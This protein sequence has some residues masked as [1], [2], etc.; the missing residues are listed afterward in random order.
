[1]IITEDS[2][3]ALTQVRLTKG[4]LYSDFASVKPYMEPDEHIAIFND[5][6]APDSTRLNIEI[7]NTL[8]M[9]E[10]NEPCFRLLVKLRNTS[11]KNL[12]NIA[13]AYFFDWD[14]GLGGNDNS[15]FPFDY[16]LPITLR[17]NPHCLAA[18]ISRQGN[19]EKIATAVTSNYPNSE[20]IFASF[21]NSVTQGENLFS[22]PEQIHYLN[23]GKS[24]VYDNIDDIAVIMGMKFPGE[25]SQGD[26]VSF[27]LSICLQDSLLFLR[28]S[29]W[30]FL[31]PE[32]SNITNEKNNN[33]LLIYPN[34]AT[35]KIIISGN[36][37]ISLELV[38][39]LGNT[40]FKTENNTE[41]PFVI[42]VSD[43]SA[44]LY[45]IKFNTTKGIT[46]KQFV[47]K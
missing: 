38:D 8:D 31:D 2:S 11:S 32:V 1:M 30:H 33:D 46:V 21:V 5:S 9:P 13:I 44:G 14:I 47:K 10:T 26:S 16:L 45:L 4:K 23:S 28:N 25:I 19:Y 15:A 41:A 27:E 22:L 34:P 20:P 7:E 29:I 36:N 3:K 35:D 18:L 12:K 40:L 24:I 42:N 43:Y 37:I 17:D 39:I 6:F